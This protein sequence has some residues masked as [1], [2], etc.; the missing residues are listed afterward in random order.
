LRICVAETFA[1]GLNMPA[2]TC[3]FTNCRKFDGQEH[4][5][6]TC[7]EYIQMAGRAGRRGIDDKGFVITMFDEHLDPL[8]ARGQLFLKSPLFSGGIGEL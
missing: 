8:V 7:S 1:L 3:V 5:W 6:I 4:R 2:R